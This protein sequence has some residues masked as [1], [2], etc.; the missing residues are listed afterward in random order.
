MSRARSIS[1]EVVV[2]GG[3]KVKTF[4]IVVLKDSPWSKAP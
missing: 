2:N 4:P 3:V 1:M